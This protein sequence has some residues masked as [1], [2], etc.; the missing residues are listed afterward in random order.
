MSA[1]RWTPTRVEPI[2]CMLA[3][4]PH[5][6]SC[7]YKGWF[8]CKDVNR[9]GSGEYVDQHQNEQVI[10]KYA[11][12]GLQPGSHVALQLERPIQLAVP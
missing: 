7:G 2:T 11:I 6:C 8:G 3:A 9:N 12:D 1:K 5:S 4:L 10:L